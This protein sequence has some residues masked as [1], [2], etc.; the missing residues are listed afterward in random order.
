MAAILAVISLTLAGCSTVNR[1]LSETETY[2]WGYR[3]ASSDFQPVCKKVNVVIPRD[4]QTGAKF[5]ST[6]VADRYCKQAKPPSFLDK[7]S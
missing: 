5:T 3:Y 7:A 6:I 1:P 2:V 4:R